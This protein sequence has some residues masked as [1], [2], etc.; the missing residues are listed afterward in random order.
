MTHTL[1]PPLDSPR[2]NSMVVPVLAVV[3]VVLAAAVGALWLLRDTGENRIDIVKRVIASWD[4]ADEDEVPFS[5]D[6]VDRWLAN[7][8]PDATVLGLAVSDPAVREITAAFDIWDE[9]VELVSEPVE[10]FEGHVSVE[11]RRTDGF[12]GAGGLVMNATERFV[13]D[14]DDEIVE[15]G[16]R[17]RQFSDY[18][19][20][21]A[22]FIE[23]YEQVAHPGET[24]ARDLGGLAWTAENAAISMATVDDFLAYSDEYPVTRP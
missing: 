9:R 2:R 24:L 10:V 5:Y 12:H 4:M 21:E 1:E 11:T 22:A 7:F 16:I 6:D 13:F 3:L 17:T 20:F 23:W 19:A 18:K 14:D 15:N 8:A